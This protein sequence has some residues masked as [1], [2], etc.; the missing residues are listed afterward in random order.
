MYSLKLDSS[1]NSLDSYSSQGSSLESSLDSSIDFQGRNNST[2]PSKMQVIKRDGRE[3][4]MFF[5]KITTRIKKLTEV[6]NSNMEKKWNFPEGI[7][8]QMIAFETIKSISSNI[9]TEEID[10]LSSTICCQYIDEHPNYNILASKICVS[11]L[12][13]NTIS[14][15][16]ETMKMCLDKNIVSGSFYEIVKTNSAEI[17]SRI[18]HDHDYE[19]DYFGYKTLESKYLFRIDGKIVERP[20]FMIMRVAIGIHQDDLKSAFET[21]DLMSNRFFTHATPT[22][23]NAGTPKPQ[24]SS[25]FLVAMKDDSIEGIFDTLKQCAL[26]S[27][28]AGGIGM[29]IHNIRGNKSPIVGTNGTSNGIVPMLRVFNETSRYVDQGGG[30]RKGSFAIYLE[31]WHCDIIDFIMLK[32]NTGDENLRARD[33]FPALWI[34][35]RFMIA[36]KNNEP[37]YLMCPNDSPGLSDVY[38]EKFNQL[39]QRYVL[40]GK[41]KSKIMARN[42]WHQITVSIIET[43]SPYI[44]YKDNVNRKN[45]QMN[46]GTIK[47]SNLCCEIM[48]YTDSEQTAVC[49]LASI[50]VNMCIIHQGDKVTYD[51]DL[52]RRITMI[53]TKNLNRVIDQNYYPVEE[54]RYSNQKHRPIGIGIQGLADLFFE[55]RLNFDSA[56]ALRLSTQIMENIQYSAILASTHLAEKDG[57]YES[58]IGSPMEKGLFQHDLW[59]YDGVLTLPWDRLRERVKR[60]G[61][62]N[63][64]FTAPMPTASTSQI[65]GNTECFEPISSNLY[66]RR[67]IAGNFMVFNKYLYRDLNRLGLWSSLMKQKIQYN[68]GSIQ[69]IKEIPND[70]KKLYRTVWEIPQKVIINMAI[71]RGPFICQSQSMNVFYA[72]PSY[73]K[74]NS[75]LMYGW[76]KGLKTGLY[77]L[78]SKPAV[79]A[80]KFGISAENIKIIEASLSEDSES[81]DSRK[82]P[83]SSKKS[84]VCTDEVCISCGS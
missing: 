19:F 8:V 46:L 41:F 56:E 35:D 15:F 36:V 74:L 50:A 17:D 43:G 26:I 2:T 58:Y 40:E 68:N 33:L 67:T 49:N 4:P 82:T 29:H 13:K 59:N 55:M 30:K 28:H 69:R 18:V 45:N 42:L 21:Y 10:N 54:S 47:S 70:I 34:P 53:V 9:K 23:F 11:N 32:R 66:S 24:L 61:V 84:Y 14:S 37:W 81:R 1:I 48:Q 7:D 79:N 57:A 51:F 63:S 73:S 72:D 25:C 76:Q 6:Q 65:L 52:L 39:Y 78:R 12:H 31:P 60:F 3:E 38:G 75:M 64:L 20:Q 5:D 44:L 71:S 83:T 16:S 80:N 22:L 27:K 77:Y 62:R